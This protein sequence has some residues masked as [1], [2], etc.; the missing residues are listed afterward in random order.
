MESIG[1][2]FLFGRLAV[3]VLIVALLIVFGIV[4]IKAA[5]KRREKRAEA[6]HKLFNPDEASDKD[7]VN[8]NIDNFSDK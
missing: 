4:L 5:K 7:T 1:Y 3:F 2:I 8:I 6:I